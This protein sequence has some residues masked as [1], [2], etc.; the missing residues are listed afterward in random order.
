MRRLYERQLTSCSSGNI[1]ARWDEARI[2]IT[3]SQTDKGLLRAE[4]IG[5]VDMDGRSLDPSKKL[6]METEMHLAVYRVRPDVGAIVHAHPP[7]ATGFAVSQTPL[8]VALTGESFAVLGEPVLAPYALMG[9]VTLA[10]N[11]ARAAQKGDV[12]LMENHGV[13]TV[14][15]D[16]YQAYD[17]MEIVEFAARIQLITKVLGDARQ[18]SEAEKQDILKWMGR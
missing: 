2:A 15:K 17:R 9:S 1:S 7:Y 18:L 10:E 16:L 11:V 4:D 3:P 12:I 5:W 8:D 14:G 13:L 6:S